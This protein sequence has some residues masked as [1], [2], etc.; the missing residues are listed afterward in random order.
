MGSELQK[1]KKWSARKLLETSSFPPSKQCG[2]LSKVSG[3]QTM[4]YHIGV[5]IGSEQFNSGQGEVKE[6]EN[7]F[8]P[9]SGCL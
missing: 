8:F 7:W 3:W 6:K 4:R 5:L 2:Y 9:P 1:K